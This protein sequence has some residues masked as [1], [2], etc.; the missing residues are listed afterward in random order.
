[1][2]RAISAMLAGRKTGRLRVHC[3]NRIPLARGLGSSA[4]AA[5]AGLAAANELIGRPMTPQ[6]L[7]EYAT[8]LDGHPDNAAAAVFG[9][10]V[11]CL[12]EGKEPRAYKLQTHPD[13]RAVVCVPELELK[14]ADARAVLPAEVSR[15]AAVHNI[16]RSALLSA[17]LSEGL[18]DRLGPAM[19]D[20]LHQ[21][22]RASLVPGF[23][24]VLTAARGAGARGACLS[25][26]GSSILALGCVADPLDKI[27]KA[28]ADAFARFEIKARSLTL[29]VAAEGLRIS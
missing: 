4:A 20:R 7:F 8:V 29:P 18:W 12:R 19:D 22:Y 23:S 9:G 27:G 2:A 6:Q 16:A 14:T 1:V 21:P 5:V 3:V 28:M 10:L 24:A 13:L 11:T 25:G 26:A 15:E 17:A